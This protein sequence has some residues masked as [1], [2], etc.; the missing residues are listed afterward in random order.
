VNNSSPNPNGEQVSLVQQLSATPVGRR[1][2]IKAGLGT[3][4]ALAA[5]SLPFVAAASPIAQV[6]GT[7]TPKPES[8]SQP[9]FDTGST[10]GLTLQFALGKYLT[11]VSAAPTT[12]A[13]GVSDLTL[14]ANGARLP[15]VAHT[16]DSRTLLKAKGGVWGAIDLDALTHYVEGVPVPSDKAMVVSVSGK[17]DNT[18]VLVSQL[19]YTP[20]DAAR[21]LA[22]LATSGTTG[23]HALVGPDRRLQ[24]LGLTPAQINSPDHVV[25]LNSIG[26]AYSTAVSLVFHHPNVTNLDK[27]GSNATTTLLAQNSDVGALGDYIAQMQPPGVATYVTATNA[28]GSQSLITIGDLAPQPFKTLQL[29]HDD[30]GFVTATTTALGTGVKAVRNQGNLGTVIDKPVSEYPIGAPFNTWI[31]P[32]GQKLQAKPYTPVAPTTLGSSL[33]ANLLKSGD[34][35][36]TRTVVHADQISGASVPVTL[37]NNWVR[38][39]WAYVQYLG[40]DGKNL[41]A[42]PGAAW[43]DTYYSQSLK[44]VP[45]VFTVFG[46]PLWDTNTVDFTLDFPQGAHTAR[47][48]Y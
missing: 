4:G 12:T 3:A 33:Q 28:D 15:L 45:Q 10:T 42:N 23:L 47:L 17:R 27:T 46:I 24:A 41:S 14:I 16:A 29:R 32:Q 5:A 25:Q 21:A 39:M 18:E 9:V 37:Y 1:W 7:P 8:T 34:M 38:W 36:G 26:D 20:T 40:K 19:I 48:L 11:P 35:Y 30:S 44:I 31:Q 43:P 6:T 13:G 22:Q 2:L